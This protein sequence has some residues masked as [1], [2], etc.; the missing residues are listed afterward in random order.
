LSHGVSWRQFVVVVH[1][2]I[3]S[4]S[5]LPTEMRKAQAQ[6]RRKIYIAVLAVIAFGVVYYN[7]RLALV[8]TSVSSIG[9][10][11]GDLREKVSHAVVPA[12]GGDV[13]DY[14]IPL[15]ADPDGSSFGLLKQRLLLYKRDGSGYLLQHPTKS[16]YWIEFSKKFPN[17]A[18][19]WKGEKGMRLDAKFVGQLTDV[20]VPS[21]KTKSMDLEATPVGPTSQG[22][23]DWVDVGKMSKMSSKSKKTKVTNLVC[24]REAGCVYDVPKVKELRTIYKLNG[25]ALKEVADG[26]AWVES[27]S[28]GGPWLFFFGTVLSTP[29]FVLVL[30]PS[31]DIWLKIRPPPAKSGEAFV[32]SR[33]FLGQVNKGKEC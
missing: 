15:S 3:Q 19:C 22:E 29:E 28:D 17:R 10:A 1:L 4:S 18:N 16:G 13:I 33:V 21:R 20:S 24:Y 11:L 32:Q 7:F 25:G 26:Q 5:H 8:R 27:N 12:V 6:S 31:R 14:V 2:V 30:D 9:S 23:G